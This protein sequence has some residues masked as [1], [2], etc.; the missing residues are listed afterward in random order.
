M[1]SSTS[2]TGGPLPVALAISDIKR[3]DPANLRALFVTERLANLAPRG[4]EARSGPG[5][6]YLTISAGSRATTERSVDGQVLALDDLSSGS[7][8]GEIFRRRTGLVPDG[9]H[10]ALGWP[11]LQRSNARQPYDAVLGLLAET[12]EEHDV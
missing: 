2:R 7:A 1:L 4:V 6:A 9:N 12:P 5:E 3:Y 11:A 8:A 10:V